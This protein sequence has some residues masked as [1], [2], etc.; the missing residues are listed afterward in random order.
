M[1]EVGCHAALDFD[2]RRPA[3]PVAFAHLRIFSAAPEAFSMDL[4]LE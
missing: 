1:L 4:S 2:F 3:D